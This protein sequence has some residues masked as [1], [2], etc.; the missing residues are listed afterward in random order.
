MT[1]IT[2]KVTDMQHPITKYIHYLWMLT[3]GI[4]TVCQRYTVN[5]TSYKHSINGVIPNIVM[6]NFI[7]DPDDRDVEV[8]IKIDLTT[9]VAD[10]LYDHD[11]TTSVFVN[12]DD[13][14]GIFQHLN[15]MF[16][17]PTIGNF[18]V[19]G[20]TQKQREKLE[21]LVLSFTK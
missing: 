6:Y 1:A 11:T 7:L 9:H 20:V 21:K 12:D 19:C 15:N 5:H 8:N 4:T 10:V 14:S 16:Q 3:A 13:L 18:T 17:D 2:H